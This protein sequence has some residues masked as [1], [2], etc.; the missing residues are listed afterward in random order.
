MEEGTQSMERFAAA[1]LSPADCR[2]A[3]NKAKAV[4][5]ESAILEPPILPNRIAQAY[6]VSVFSQASRPSIGKYQASTIQVAIAYT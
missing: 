3:I 4:L 2:R 5:E 1:R 6:G